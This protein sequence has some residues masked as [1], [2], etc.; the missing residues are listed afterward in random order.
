MHVLWCCDGCREGKGCVMAVG[1]V[2]MAVMWGG[3][4]VC[5]GCGEVLGVTCEIS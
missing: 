5:Y 2:V 4:G 3:K 1:A